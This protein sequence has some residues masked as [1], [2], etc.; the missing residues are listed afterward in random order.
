[1][2]EGKHIMLQG[3]MP[4]EARKLF[5]SQLFEELDW[6]NL[7]EGKL[8]KLLKSPFMFSFNPKVLKYVGRGLAAEDALMQN[9]SK[10][11][12]SVMEAYLN[13]DNKL[14][15]KQRLSMAHT[16]L[17]K[18]EADIKEAKAQANQEG[19]Y[20]GAAPGEKLSGIQLQ[21]R[22]S[23]FMYRVY[24]IINQ[25]RSKDELAKMIAD[26]AE[27]RAARITFNYEPK[28]AIAGNV[29]K[30]LMGLQTYIKPTVFF[31]P[32]IRI[33]TNIV[34][35][36]FM[37]SPVGGILAGMYK[38]G[39]LDQKKAK[40]SDEEVGLM[41]IKSAF[42]MGVF[43]LFYAMSDDDDFM[44]I[45]ANGTGDDRKNYELQQTG[46]RPYTIKING[47]QISYKAS[48]FF[49]LLAAV[50]TIRDYTKYRNDNE[51]AGFWGD[52]T[53]AAAGFAR[54][55]FDQSWIQGLDEMIAVANPDDMEF[56]TPADWLNKVGN[57][58]SKVAAGLFVS[59]ATKQIN[60]VVDMNIKDP[61]KK[62]DTPAERFV[63]DIPF[64][65]DYL[66]DDSIV[67]SW[68]DPVI[69]DAPVGFIPFRLKGEQGSILPDMEKDEFLKM[70]HSDGIFI[71]RPRNNKEI[72]NPVTLKSRPLTKDEY[73]KY[74]KLAG[75][76]LKDKLYNPDTMSELREYHK[77]K[78]RT[79]MKQIV[80]TLKSEAN[81][82]A[83]LE[84]FGENMDID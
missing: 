3:A 28:G 32:F 54:S 19:Y 40:L 41:A 30:G 60:K 15:H 47:V 49:P 84:L 78:D 61:I 52:M 46:W 55:I 24:E 68:G 59:N 7:E 20:F 21:K 27:S 82:E 71:G 10:E 70:L 12:Y 9:A 74:Y 73:Y 37:Y 79:T 33:I 77:A 72:I 81:N 29:Y 83:F 75:Q 56:G 67:D 34:D 5:Q 69:T 53:E 63:R 36:Y 65:G 39:M 11:A 38:I 76:K 43:A 51:A 45:T 80:F 22:K 4:E 44:Q 48:P 17:F 23:E 50:G 13:I 62:A 31:M 8:K 26:Q 16:A 35:N 64:V 1:M 6:D 2:W 66:L 57:V 14:S 18:T 58:F 42:A 25:K